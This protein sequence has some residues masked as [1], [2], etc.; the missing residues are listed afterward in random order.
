MSTRPSKQLDAFD[1]PKPD[2]LQPED[3]AS[4]VMFALTAPA[5]ANVREVFVMPTN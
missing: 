4:S 2:K 5:H 1:N 3:I